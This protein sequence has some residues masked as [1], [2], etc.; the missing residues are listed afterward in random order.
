MRGKSRKRSSKVIIEKQ[1]P[2]V[3]K[4]V[5]EEESSLSDY[6][7]SDEIQR[8]ISMIGQGFHLKCSPDFPLFYEFCETLR[9]DAPLE[10]LSDVGFRLVGP[11]EILHLGSKEPVKKGQ[12]SN[13]YRFY[14]DPPEFV[15]VIIC[16]TEQYHIGYFRDSCESKPF[17][18]KSTPMSN[19]VL[20]YCGQNL[21]AF[22]RSILQEKCAESTDLLKSLIEFA[23]L[24]NIPTGLSS[25]YMKDRKKRQVCAT[26]NR[27]GLMIDVT[28]NDIGYRPL[29][30]SYAELNKRLEDVVSEK[31]KERQLI[32][33][34]P[35]DEL[36]TCVQF[37]NDEGDFGQGLELGLS[38]LAFHPKAQ[39]LE[40]ANIFNNK[41]K[42]LLSV[43]YTLANR[44]EFSQVI[45]SHMDDRRIE[46]LT[47][48]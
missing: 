5:S 48:T 20:E 4:T 18:A 31:S 34:A 6:P 37:A 43:G 9:A 40:T 24:K 7:I 1:K 35:I 19:G 23:S 47:F 15:T 28:K 13:Y 38:I 10:A 45:Q 41:I 46:P 33:F 42:H 12:W 44:K 21:F 3:S 17:L 8:R 36:I 14:H 29:N 32:K 30:I 22:L 25:F 39:P 2:K 27:I 11:F 26:T 16:T